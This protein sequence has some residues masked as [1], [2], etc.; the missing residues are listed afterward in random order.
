MLKVYSSMIHVLGLLRARCGKRA[1]RER[2]FD[3]LGFTHYWVSSRKGRWVV[4]QRTAKSRFA[5]GLKAIKERCRELRHHTLKEQHEALCRMLR[6]HFNYYGITGNAEALTRYR[7]EAE[8]I[9]G[10]SLARRNR[11]HFAWRRYKPLLDRFPLPV[12]R[13]LGYV[14]L[15][16]GELRRQLSEVQAMLVALVR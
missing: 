8:R 11:R 4:K 14:E 6:G 10:R 16:D 2:S 5:R 13:P 9:W 7:N 12:P 3:F 1:Q 15:V